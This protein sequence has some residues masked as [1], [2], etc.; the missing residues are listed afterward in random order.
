LRLNSSA[1]KCH[2]SR[3]I[4][5]KSYTYWNAWIRKL[6][7]NSHLFQFWIMDDGCF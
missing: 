2:A 7:R 4:F 6:H 3:N 1:N 5:K